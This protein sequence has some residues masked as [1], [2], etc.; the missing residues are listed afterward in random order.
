MREDFIQYLWKFKKFDFTRLKTTSNQEVV[1]KNVG[2]HNTSQAGPDFIHARLIIDNQDWAGTVE[3]H[4]KSSDWYVHNHENDIAYDNVILHLVW[5][6]DAQVYRKDNSL[7]PVV[8]LKEYIPIEVVKKY[9]ALYD[10]NSNNWISCHKQI[11]TVPEFVK[12]NWLERLCI[13]RLEKKSLQIQQLLNDVTNDWEGL[14]FILLCKNFGLKSNADSFL[15]IAKSLGYSVIRK[16]SDQHLVL[17][18]LLFGHANLL[19]DVDEDPYGI[20]LAKE[21]AFLKTKFNLSEVKGQPL[22]FFRQRPSNF[23]TIRLAQFVSLYH[24]NHQ[25]F[26]AIIATK[27]LNGFYDLFDITTSAYWDTHYVFGKSSK[28][29]SKKLS[30]SFINLLVINTIIPIKFLYSKSIGVANDEIIALYSQ[31]NAEQNSIVTR[32]SDCGLTIKNAMQSQASLELKNEYCDRKK[33]LDCGIGNYLLYSE[34]N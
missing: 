23:P 26:A 20:S 9:Q 10:N 4:V 3:V 13:E 31:L 6:D 11:K 34:E 24:H 17:E 33:C 8:E 32:F 21:Y 30:K 16:C 18:A 29:R 2:V 7:I 19:N 14:L 22:Q 27:T 1:I 5:E 28:K 15:A 25:L 12:T